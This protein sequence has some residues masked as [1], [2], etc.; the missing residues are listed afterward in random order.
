MRNLKKVLSLVMALVMTMSLAT[1]AFAA[2]AATTTTETTTGFT[3]AASI[4]NTAAVNM[5]NGLNVL[6]GTDGKFNPTGTLT[7]AEAAAI[8]CR[9]LLGTDVAS[10]LADASATTTFTDMK[11]SEWAIG[12][13][14]YCANVGIING[15][16]DNK[17]DPTAK[18][19]TYQFAK[20]LLGALGYGQNDEYVGSAWATAVG[21]QAMKLGILP[22]G[23][24][25]ENC[26]RDNAALYA[27]NTLFLATAEYNSDTGVYTTYTSTVSGGN[28]VK[29][30]NDS[31]AKINFNFATATG[32]LRFDNTNGFY[33][34]TGKDGVYNVSKDIKVTTGATSALI[35][36]NVFVDALGTT[37]FGAVTTKDVTLN[38]FT[39]GK[40]VA[41]TDST[42]P[43]YVASLATSV[44]V[45]YNGT[46]YTATVKSV[47]TASVGVAGATYTT[48]YEL[49]G[50]NLY[51]VK[52]TDST[53]ITTTLL[54][55]ITAGQIVD[56][57]DTAVYNTG[58]KV[59]ENDGK[60]DQVNVTNKT[61]ATISTKA[62]SVATDGK[63]TIYGTTISSASH[64]EYPT[65]LVKGDVVLYYYDAA[66]STYVVERAVYVEGEYT[67]FTAA[68]NAPP[69]PDTYTVGGTGYSASGLSS[70]SSGLATTLNVGATLGL[71]LDN[72]NNVVKSKVVT[73]A[74]TV[75]TGN[76]IDVVM[77]YGI[78]DAYDPLTTVNWVQGV[79]ADGTVVTY[80]LSAASV[81]AAT[82]TGAIAANATKP[83]LYSYN[84]V[85]EAGATK[86]K[87]TAIVA[88]TDVKVNHFTA[89]TIAS[90]TLK[91]GATA[92][93]Y[94]S[95]VKFVYVEGK[96]SSL[97]VTV[98]TGMQVGTAVTANDWYL[99][100]DGN[101]SDSITT[102][103]IQATPTTALTGTEL[104]YLAD[105]A[106][107][108][109]NSLGN[110]FT[111]YINGVA[112]TV[113]TA[114]DPTAAGFYTYSIDSKGVYTLT[115]TATGV[116]TVTDATIYNGYF[117]A[118]GI[119]DYKYTNVTVT[120][121]RAGLPG[122]AVKI[123]SIEVLADALA[124]GYTATLQYV[125][126]AT[127]KE[128]LTIYVTA[129]T[130]P[131]VSVTL[132]D[133]A[134]VVG[135][136]LAGS[137]NATHTVYTLTAAKWAAGD[138]VTFST[139]NLPDG[140]TVSAALTCTLAAGGTAATTDFAA[141]TGILTLPA[142]ST[143]AG[144]YTF[145]ITTVDSVYGATNGAGF[146]VDL[147]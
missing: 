64:V 73:Q 124:D 75:A 23:T 36:T 51:E 53:H 119:S 69:T 117:N 80:P 89:T 114:A 105:F 81:T 5:L 142:G 74:A 140:V 70:A 38:T 113:N 49:V 59:W 40:F 1:G 46:A 6:V 147:G 55:T 35:G 116:G 76:Y 3:D 135:S 31:L 7:R 14:Q 30:D 68:I 145:T 103:F 95:D 9:V 84:L 67:A 92:H 26:T 108:G 102:A 43:D 27:Y 32:I 56:L 24:V 85:T 87:L 34:D 28:T 18:V 123:N 66:R 96:G 139:A 143:N 131:T 110:T 58:D 133:A 82:V 146:T 15:V 8:I 91:D 127:N 141:G 94:A 65:D 60:I 10:T 99:T 17:F 136:E 137:W 44:K 71:Y 39:N 62:A 128:V 120:D 47:A 52:T 132:T 107:D 118:T 98:K 77:T 57:V 93:Y 97:K 88:A 63:V 122:T 111:G 54:F 109:I 138:K 112:K 134:V 130:A 106:V 19:T 104:F 86:I 4:K 29:S 115:S 16:G 90:T 129:L 42:T 12:Y 21:V 121:L 126:D 144:L 101:A 41:K 50:A 100:K 72:N 20:M 25:N 78:A 48:T 37:A 22:K 61:V 45:V 13:V 125:V 83:V 33:V 11:G 79:L 2:T